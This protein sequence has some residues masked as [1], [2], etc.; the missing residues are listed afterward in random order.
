MDCEL[1]LL[2]FSLGGNFLMRWL[3][4]HAKNRLENPDSSDPY[5]PSHVAA[6]AGVSL[7][8]DVSTVGIHLKRVRMGLY[9]EFLYRMALWPY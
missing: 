4:S 9:N 2:G 3:G 7:P 8:F 5:L 1:Y 6:F